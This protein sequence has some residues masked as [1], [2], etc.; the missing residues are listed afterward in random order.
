MV[1]HLRQHAGLELHCGRVHGADVGAQA[2]AR[3]QVYVLQ[4]LPSLPTPPRCI[5]SNDKWPPAALLPALWEDN[6]DALLA[7]PLVAAFGG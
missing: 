7:F 1:P 3:G 6:R 2:R 5:C 4:S